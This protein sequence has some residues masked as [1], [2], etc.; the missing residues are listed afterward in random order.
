MSDEWDDPIAAL[1][2]LLKE[3]KLRPYFHRPGCPMKLPCRCYVLFYG[4]DELRNRSPEE[5]E[6]LR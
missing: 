4:M 2:A 3:A 6:L 5:W 1:C